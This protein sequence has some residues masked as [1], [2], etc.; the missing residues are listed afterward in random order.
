MNIG[1][2]LSFE[3]FHALYAVISL[4]MALM[5]TLFSFEY[6]RHEPHRLRYGTF[7]ALTMAATLGV[8]LSGDLM[9]AY[10]C[11]EIVSLAS[12]PM[13]AQEETG[14]AMRAGKTYITISVIGGMVALMGMFL[15]YSAVGTF[16]FTELRSA[17]TACPD[18]ARL[19]WASG[20][21]LFGFGAKAGMF[22]LHVW[23]P[24]AHP[25]APA[26]ASALLS[27]LLTKVGVYGI[28]AV[29]VF[30]MT[31]NAAWGYT[32]L[33]LGVATMLTGAIL[34]ILAVDLKR[35]IA[36]S[37]V[38]QIGFILIGV[39]MTVLLGEE[40][41]LA[42]RGTV[43]HMVNHSLFKLTLFLAAGVAAMNTHTLDLNRLRGWGRGKP[44]LAFCFASG[45][46]G[47]AGVPLFSGFVSKSLLHEAIVEYAERSGAVSVKAAEWLF[48]I[49]GGMTL[50]YML[51]IFV[52]LFVEKPREPL[53]AKKSY[54]RPLT[55]FAVLVPAAAIPVLGC[56]PNLLMD[57]I[58]DLG[59]SFLGFTASNALPY[60]TA[61]NLKGSAIS[62]SIGAVLYFAV[63]RG[64]T[65]RRRTDG[66]RVYVNRLP[67]WA[68]LEKSVYRPLIERILPAVLGFFASLA[69]RLPE[70]LFSRVIMPVLS[71]TAA[72]CDVL[73]DTLIAILGRTVYRERRPETPPPVGTRTSYAL[74]RAADGIV[75]AYARARH[76]TRQQSEAFTERFAKGFEAFHHEN[77]LIARSLSFAMM[78]ACVGMFLTF[79]YLMAVQFGGA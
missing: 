30:I 38:S 40:G 67:S 3:G 44:M 45:A 43:L 42:A 74:G 15:L 56:L 39:S 4:V 32:L 25:V 36:C 13:V 29:S 68:S 22:P 18:K 70:K 24:E 33:W 64:L 12:Y 59:E 51:K 79:V 49:A 50:A 7:V 58:A 2:S 14:G 21:L 1:F 55:R 77:R 20:C 16:S 76:R 19:A 6:L 35:I 41:T 48:L 5:T 11:F 8:F 52:A 66:Q 75:G 73:P 26:P 9:T 34:G 63:V 27:G 37:S 54:A 71:V 28:L 61:E 47:L 69:D 23:L 31:G 78:M 10:V 62:L 46:A 17:C 57:R 72:L 53:P 65:M 60:F